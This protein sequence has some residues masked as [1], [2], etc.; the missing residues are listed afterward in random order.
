MQRLLTVF[1]AIKAILA[2]ITQDAE[3]RT[4]EY[5]KDIEMLDKI[6]S[7]LDATK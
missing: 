7:A 6:L 4:Q 1:A 5:R 3:R 2:A